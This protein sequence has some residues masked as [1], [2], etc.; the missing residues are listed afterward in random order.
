LKVT[1]CQTL[2]VKL[3]PGQFFP[4]LESISTMARLVGAGLFAVSLFLS[5]LFTPEH[6]TNHLLGLVGHNETLAEEQEFLSLEQLNGEASVLE[7]EE[8]NMKPWDSV[9]LSNSE[10]E[11]DETGQLN[12]LLVQYQKL[13]QDNNKLQNM[14]SSKTTQSMKLVPEKGS[15]F[16]WATYLIRAVS[17]IVMI[18][19]FA[20]LFKKITAQQQTKKIPRKGATSIE[21][22]EPFAVRKR[23]LSDELSSAKAAIH[24]P[25]NVEDHV[26]AGIEE[27]TPASEECTAEIVT[28]EALDTHEDVPEQALP[29]FIPFVDRPSEDSSVEDSKMEETLEEEDFELLSRSHLLGSSFSAKEE[30][31]VP[32]VLEQSFVDLPKN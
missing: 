15:P 32:N 6:L 9:K 21:I 30:P 11:T 17:V 4:S 1:I 2:L 24:P 20:F 26:D 28:G 10:K 3:F 8:T 29:E 23:S 13:Q 16:P 7:M 19:S 25:P 31:T 12:A 14:L 18:A 22:S 5:A 27:D